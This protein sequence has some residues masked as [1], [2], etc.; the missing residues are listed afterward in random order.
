MNELVPNQITHVDQ[1]LRS[2]ASRNTRSAYERDLKEYVSFCSGMDP[3]SFSSLVTFRDYLISRSA[4]S[5][6][7]RK[8]SAVKSFMSFL[9]SQGLITANP[10]ANLK[11]PR[12][13]A[14]THTEAFDDFEVVRMLEAVDV[15]TFYGSSHKLALILLF[16]LGLRRS[17]LAVLRVG[18]LMDYRGKR[19]IV[20]DGKGDKQRL[21]P[22]TQL[23]NDEV[24]AYL[25][26]YERFTGARL[27]PSDYLIQS[28][29]LERNVNPVDTSTIYRLVKSYAA[30]VGVSKRVSPHSCRATMISHLL[31]KNVS[32][33]SVADIAGH[34]SITTT[35]N[36]YDRKRDAITN[37]AI[38][39]VSYGSKEE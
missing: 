9:A 6:V 11:V 28:S 34:S 27:S 1:F 10:A 23:V 33:R 32:P 24:T 31:E 38:E 16:N 39:S 12:S 30:K 14:M 13:R 2:F 3:M 17:E 4:P 5:T 19:F 22:I 20:V 29:Q 7:I 21:I 25:D 8:F 15:S 36:S 18:S 26:R 35:I 37:K